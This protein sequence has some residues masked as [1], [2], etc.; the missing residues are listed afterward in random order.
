MHSTVTALIQM[1]DEWLKNM[2]YGKSNGVVFL[3][4][5]K[6][7]DSINQHILLNKINEQF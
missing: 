5:K 7:I 1:C 4:I 2:D 3:D 6:A